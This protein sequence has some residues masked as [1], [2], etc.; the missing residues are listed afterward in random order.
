MEM[1]QNIILTLFPRQTFIFQ[2]SKVY[3]EIKKETQTQ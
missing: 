2:D 3:S 1:N